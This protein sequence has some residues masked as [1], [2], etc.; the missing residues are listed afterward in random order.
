MPHDLVPGLLSRATELLEAE[1]AALPAF[2]PNALSAGQD[3]IAQVL[4]TTARSLA[5]N[6]PYF[7]PL[8]A[9]QMLKPPHPLA[10]AA[11]ALA[12]SINPNNHAR[13]GGRASSEMEIEAVRGIAAMFGWADS[14]EPFLGHLTS[15]G[16]LANLEALWVAGQSN[17]GKRI[18][19]SEQAHYTHR[20]ISAVLKLQYAEI[21]ADTCGRISLEALQTELRKGD[22]GTVVATLGTTSLGAVDPLDEILALRERYGF[23]VHVDAAYGG[24]FKL[25]PDALAEPARR[26]FATTSHVDSIVIDPHK[27]GLQPYGCGCVLFRDATVGRFYKHDSPYT[28]FTS[29]Q[30]HLGE[31][32]LECSRAGA[33]AVALWATQRLLPLVPGG[34]FAQGLSQGRSAALELDRILRGDGR[35]QPLAAGAPELDIVVWK[36]KAPTAGESSQLA[37][38]V[39]DAC[40][41]RDLHLALVQLPVT[42][43]VPSVADANKIEA[44]L[45]T[46]L[47]SVLMKPEHE[48]WLGRIWDRLAAACAETIGDLKK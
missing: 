17:P 13:D 28:Y 4:E 7:H 30:L 29:R 43:F 31:I 48:A 25:I 44:G 36:L 23:R 42:W 39:F 45:V 6:Y 5:D 9:G 32:S 24:Y 1:F 41:A 18:V 27:H 38:D 35:F 11:Y 3:A 46:C 37:Q 16:T 20:R 19:G 47:R 33:A 21:P 34:A 2:E 12:M 8:Y 22:V 40:A 10:R 14:E 26:A 15:S